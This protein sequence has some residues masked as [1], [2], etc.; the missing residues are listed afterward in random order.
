[1]KNIQWQ[2]NDAE[3]NNFFCFVLSECCYRICRKNNELEGW[4]LN[5]N[6]ANIFILVYSL[7]VSDS[8]ESWLFRFIDRK[9]KQNK[10]RIQAKTSNFDFRNSREN[11][12]KKKKNEHHI[13]TGP[14]A[15]RV[16]IEFHIDTMATTIHSIIHWCRKENSLRNC[17]IWLAINLL[18]RPM[19][20]LFR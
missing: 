18:T 19:R 14:N 20:L 13:D 17:K 12:T 10:I 5:L 6:F 11:S 1:M 3:L 15:T 16:Q 2:T 7:F 8:I 4:K 9:K